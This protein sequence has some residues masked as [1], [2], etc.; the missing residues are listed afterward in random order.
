MDNPAAGQGIHGD[1][2]GHTQA[3][4]LPAHASPASFPC[5]SWASDEERDA[6]HWNVRPA[7]AEE[8]LSWL[9][10]R[11][12]VDPVLFAIEAARTLLMPYQAQALLDL[13][14][15]PAEV[16]TFYGLDPSF[17]KRAVLQP[18]GHGLGKTR[19]L[20]V[21]ESWHRYTHKFSKGLFTAPTS[22]QLTD[23]LFG[24][25][26]KLHRRIKD[27]W[28]A[29]ANDW[30]ILGGSIVHKD[31]DY[32]DWFTVAR[33]ARADNPEGMQGAHALDDDDAYGDLAALFGEDRSSGPSGGILIGAEEASG[34]PD[35]VRETIE[36]S[37]SEEGARFIAAGNPTRPDGWFAD[38]LDKTGRY[39]VHPLDCRMSNRTQIY[40]LPYR[41]FGGT[42]HQLRL[43]GFV[44]PG[45]WEEIL[46]DCDGDEDADR[47]RVRV[48]GVKPRSASEQCIRTHWIDQ[49][50]ARA[51]DEA[52]KTAPAI[53]GLDF[54]LS[55]DK[56][57][58]AV[59]QGFNVRDVQEWLPKDKPD[60]VTLDA[61]YRAIDAQKLYRA[62]FIIGDANGVGRGAMEYL[63]KY[64]RERPELGVTVIF[65]NA[66][67]GA[68]DNKRFYR[69]RDEMW[70]KSGREFF[71]N[72][73]THMPKFPGLRKQLC[74]PGYGEDATRKIW[75]ESKD[76]I[77][78]RTG[79]PSGN[80]ADAVLQTLEVFVLDDAN[81][82]KPKTEPDHPPVFAAHFKR[83]REQREGGEHGIYIH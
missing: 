72:P 53:I 9:L 27:R 26:R 77:K 19:G 79:E 51:P 18:S 57:A 7:S 25:I 34:I 56:H 20:A 36:G 44:Q 78:K 47:F 50:E 35:K 83:W 37:L 10:L 68:R 17:P 5:R 61:A 76:E 40:R 13:A 38:D 14:D 21:A 54:G 80:G 16:Y 46:A 30:D 41:D 58:M 52:S 15:V 23:Q 65:F 63:A 39:A 22:D 12:R 55:G 73:R 74:T 64:Y 82:D 70:F 2:A 67:A 71:A 29:L 45:Y 24:E 3:L 42:V 6:W 48:R 66:G 69:R 75:V 59:R 43:R 81:Q 28:P 8:Q 1:A 62:K 49:A 4:V 33:T 11:W 31:P 32:G 60:E